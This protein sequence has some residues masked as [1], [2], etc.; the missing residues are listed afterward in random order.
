ME[1]NVKD[2]YS[3]PSQFIH[4]YVPK[5]LSP[6]GALRN[7]YRYFVKDVSEKNIGPIFKGQ[8]AQE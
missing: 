3:H 4:L 1:N 7:V 8:S 6:S 2:K 5:D